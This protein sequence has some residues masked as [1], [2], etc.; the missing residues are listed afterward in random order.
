MDGN[1][2]VSGTIPD[3]DH[4]IEPD[5]VHRTVYVDPGLFE[6]EMA[7]LWGR[8]WIYVGHE[9]QVPAP[10]DY[11]ATEIAREPVIMVRHEDGD[12]RLL[13]NRCAHKGAEVVADRTGNVKYFYCNYHGWTYRLDG[14]LANLPMRD[15]YDGTCF[16]MDNPEFGL[17]RVAR[18]ET[19]RGFVFGSL[20]E[21][22]PDLKTF[23]GPTIEAFDDMCDRSPEGGVEAFGTCART[24]Q[25]SNWKFFVE[26]QLDV[27]H[28]GIVHLAAYQAAKK[29]GGKRYDSF[30]DQPRTLQ[31]LQAQVPPDPDSHWAKLDSANFKYGH[32]NF[33]GYQSPRGDDPVTLEYEALL[34]GKYGEEKAE[35]FLNRSFHHTVVYPCLS[36][37]SAF[38]Q[39]RVLKP[40]AVDKTLMEIWHFRL[41][42][43]PE[44]FTR[45]NLTYANTVNSPMTMISAD[46]YETWWRCHQ[47]LLSQA[48]DWVSI[49][50]DAGRDIA[51]G[52]VLRSNTGSSEVFQRNQYAAWKDYMTGTI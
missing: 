1:Q 16:S 39:L 2:H 44:A 42:G 46:D 30:D 29:V 4:L 12:I 21:D 41:K 34:K 14:S 13:H 33:L 17:P 5:R 48:N 38:Q 27:V 3:I 9:S 45:R 36:V 6:K 25:R 47:G 28:A 40:I 51:D 8:A 52:D 7:Q 22:G 31:M 35:T 20:A 43:A 37:Q 18:M 24:V 26:N 32:S 49:H 50:R 15:G 11:F 10:G 19:Y 23:L